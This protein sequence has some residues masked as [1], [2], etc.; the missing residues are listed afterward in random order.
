MTNENGKD[1]KK[2]EEVALLQAFEEV[3]IRNIEAC[4]A[5]ANETRRMFREL[6]AKF[7]FLNNLWENHKKLLEGD[8]NLMVQLLQDKAAGGTERD[9]LD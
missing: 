9:D 5:H 3:E 2:T 4:I 8:R 6:E 7:V 1:K